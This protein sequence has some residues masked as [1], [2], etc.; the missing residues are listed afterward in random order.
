MDRLDQQHTSLCAYISLI[1]T[2]R[3][4][5]SKLL[6]MPMLHLAPRGLSSLPQLLHQPLTIK[7]WQTLET[8]PL[9]RHC[10]SPLPSALFLLPCRQSYLTHRI[11]LFIHAGEVCELVM[12]GWDLNRERVKVFTSEKQRTKFCF[13]ETATDL[14]LSEPDSLGVGVGSCK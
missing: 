7:N 5:S 13:G 9:K 4:V 8:A 3:V 10:S 2:M 11:P 1:S 12:G 14:T 6:T